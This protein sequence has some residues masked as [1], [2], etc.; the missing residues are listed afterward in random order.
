[1]KNKKSLAELQDEINSSNEKFKVNFGTPTT[2]EV[3]FALFGR[4]VETLVTD[5]AHNYNHE[6]DCLYAD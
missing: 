3:V 5:M 2:E 4:S 1:M 6:F